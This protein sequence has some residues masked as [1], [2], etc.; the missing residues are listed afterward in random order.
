MSVLTFH[1]TKIHSIE[2]NGETYIK[3]TDIAR[4]LNYSDASKLAA[5]YRRHSSEFLPSEVLKP[6]VGLQ[7]SIKAPIYFNA[8]G[9]ALIAMLSQTSRAAEFRRWIVG[10][11]KQHTKSHTKPVQT[12]MA[13]PVP[14]SSNFTEK[15]LRDAAMQACGISVDSKKLKAL[16]AG[17]GQLLYL[18]DGEGKESFLLVYR[19]A[20]AKSK[21]LVETAVSLQRDYFP[22]EIAFP[23]ISRISL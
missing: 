13:L 4:A 16:I 19:E 6:T 12:Q 15:Q 22:A 5:L 1:D 7:K 17:M 11:I 18:M 8:D 10:V 23:G 14:K 9:A 2:S 21:E 3:G 20:E